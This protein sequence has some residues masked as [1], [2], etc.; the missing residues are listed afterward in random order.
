M[1]ARKSVTIPVDISLLEGKNKQIDLIVKRVELTPELLLIGKKS[2][3]DL[4]PDFMSMIE[5]TISRFKKEPIINGFDIYVTMKTNTRIIHSKSSV[6]LYYEF[7]EESD[8]IH[9]MKVKTLYVKDLFYHL[10]KIKVI[11]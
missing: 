3:F 11:T 7:E 4:R 8:I 6:G 10:L 2:Y 1:A 5:F 9:M